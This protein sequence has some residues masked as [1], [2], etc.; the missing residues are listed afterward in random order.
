MFALSFVDESPAFAFEARER[1]RGDAAD[2]D[3]EAELQS[4]LLGDSRR[5][6][7]MI[8]DFDDEL[9]HGAVLAGGHAVLDDFGKAVQDLLDGGGVNIHAADDHH[10]V[11]AAE[12]AAV[13]KHEAI[14]TI[15]LATS[16]R[17]RSP[18]R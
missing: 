15:R 14:G 7:Q 16:G 11:G 5:L 17:T 13:E 4:Q 18:V 3:F 10:V 2:V 8:F 6:L 12:D 9:V 1:H